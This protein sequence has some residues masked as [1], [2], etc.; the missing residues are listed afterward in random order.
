MG[1]ETKERRTQLMYRQ[2]VNP[3]QLRKE[4]EAKKREAFL[5]ER[6]DFFPYSHEMMDDYFNLWNKRHKK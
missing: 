1:A 4:A 6:P 5:K 3:E 2:H